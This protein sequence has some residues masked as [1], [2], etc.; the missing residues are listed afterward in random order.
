MRLPSLLAI[1]I[2][3]AAC[4]GSRAL[5]RPAPPAAS[6]PPAAAVEPR[7]DA[8]ADAP[9]EAAT[10]TSPEP[11]AHPVSTTTAAEA[12][13][14]AAEAPADAVFAATVR[15]ILASRCTPCHE[16]GGRMYERLPFDD[17]SV[18]ASHAESVVRRL[19]EPK[20]REAVEAWLARRALPR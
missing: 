7:G 19:K 4:A 10:S 6:A 3:L 8:S 5:E 1:T 9:A 16:K 20:D 18:V 11:P 17:G 13:T 15:P 12:E 14:P 2:P